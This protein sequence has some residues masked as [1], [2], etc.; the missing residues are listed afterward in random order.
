MIE[1]LPGYLITLCLGNILLISYFSEEKL[2]KARKIDLKQ[3]LTVLRSV[4]SNKILISF[5]SGQ[6]E[7]LRIDNKTLFRIN[8]KSAD[9][10]S[11]I[12][13]T[14]INIDSQT[15]LTSASNQKVRL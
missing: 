2:S 4:S 5:E 3:S 11:A 9:A 6:S 1:E 13:C 8:N 15:F 14:D 10:D 12:L 7:L